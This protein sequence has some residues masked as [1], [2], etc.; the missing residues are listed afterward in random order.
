[1]NQPFTALSVE[2]HFVVTKLQKSYSRSFLDYLTRAQS[3]ILGL[4]RIF[5]NSSRNCCKII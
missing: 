1:V 3:W 2:H 4:R 5:F